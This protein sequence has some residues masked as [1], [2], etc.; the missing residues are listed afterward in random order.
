MNKP[1]FLALATVSA[2]LISC[3]NSQEDSFGYVSPP[4][5]QQA[6]HSNEAGFFQQPGGVSAEIEAEQDPRND[7]LISIRE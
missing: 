5:T 6:G 4:P 1:C 2:V 7:S 3:T